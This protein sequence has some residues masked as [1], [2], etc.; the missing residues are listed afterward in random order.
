MATALRLS[1]TPFE[2]AAQAFAAAPEASQGGIPAH[3]DLDAARAPD[4]RAIVAYG[5]RLGQTLG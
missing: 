4:G 5:Q 3:A 1:E 2:D